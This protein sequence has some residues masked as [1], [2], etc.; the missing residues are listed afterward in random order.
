MMCSSL[1]IV[2]CYHILTFFL[3]MCVWGG[4]HTSCHVQGLLLALSSGIFPGRLSGPSGLATCKANSLPIVL[5]LQPFIPIFICIS[6]MI[7]YAEHFSYTF[8]NLVVSAIFIH[9][10]WWTSIF[11]ILFAV[12]FVVNTTGSI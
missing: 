8:G 1:T 3:C 2:K 7:S 11:F 4:N 9:R 6:M 10:A 12:F 5:S